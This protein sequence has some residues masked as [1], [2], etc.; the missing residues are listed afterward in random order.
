MDAEHTRHY[1]SVRKTHKLSNQVKLMRQDEIKEKVK[2]SQDFTDLLTVYILSEKI[3]AKRLFTPDVLITKHIN[4]FF[5]CFKPL[6][7]ISR[8]YLSLKRCTDE[9][10]IISGNNKSSSFCVLEP[11]IFPY[12]SSV[13]GE[14]VT[15]NPD[16]NESDR[17]GFR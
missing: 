17:Q 12:N 5:C 14:Q 6:Y 10:Y 4:G 16:S 15:D 2:F 8:P 1:N 3:G 13:N 9:Q 7:E 11:V